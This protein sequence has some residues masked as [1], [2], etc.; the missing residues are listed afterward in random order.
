MV[1]KRVRRRSVNRLL[2]DVIAPYVVALGDA[3]R[4]VYLEL[5]PAGHPAQ[6]FLQQALPD[7]A[8]RA[9]GLAVPAHR[10]AFQRVDV[11]V[12]V[13]VHVGDLVGELV[14]DVGH[15]RQADARLAASGGTL[16][17][18]SPTPASAQAA[19]RVV[20]GRPPAQ[21][22]RAAA[23]PS[24][25][26]HAQRGEVGE[27]ELLVQVLRWIIVDVLGQ[28]RQ[29]QN[30]VEAILPITSSSALMMRANLLG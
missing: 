14:E 16:K 3:R 1:I 29:V 20:K 24:L 25:Q 11:L 18:R 22:A 17:A 2:E 9:V 27:I 30:G 7:I 23:R 19:Q 8:H 26:R 10:A 5:V 21:P 28:V 13:V 6:P 15:G 12:A 4:Q